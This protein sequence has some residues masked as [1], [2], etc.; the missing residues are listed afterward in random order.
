[1]KSSDANF[2]FAPRLIEWHARHG[3][4]DLPWQ[5]TRDPYRIWVSEIMLQQT[6][7]GT[8]IPYYQ[9]FMASFPTV[10][11]LADADDEKVL[12]HWSG[13]GYY[14]R[15]RNLHRAARMVRDQHGGEVPRDFDAIQALPG[16]G[17]STAAAISAFAFD[18]RRAILDGNV[19]RVLTRCFGVEGFPGEKAVENRLWSLA[20]A[21]L[22]AEA[23]DVAIYIQAQMD[24]GATVC[25]RTRPACIACPLAAQCTALRDGRVAELPGKKPRKAIPSRSTAMLILMSGYEVL[26]ERRPPSGI[27]GGLWCFPEISLDEDA[28][29]LANVRFGAQGTLSEPLGI[30]EHGFTH[31]NLAI[32]SRV[33]KVARRTHRAAQP[34][35]LWMNLDDAL[36]AAIPKPMKTLLEALSGLSRAG[37]KTA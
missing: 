6:Q 21:V 18:E 23:S 5:G 36:Q 32:H 37:L 3:R 28:A 27:W 26:L 12:A 22:P 33:V 20:E 29:A 30:I 9:R 24:L 14:A 34:G 25:T 1:M 11:A 35:T 8:V 13:L 4:H 2:Q 16:I 7:V 10:T 31:F 15:A 19:K 17:R